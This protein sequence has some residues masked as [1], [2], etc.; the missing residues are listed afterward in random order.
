MHEIKNKI[1]C[2]EKKI[3]VA[4]RTIS[5]VRKVYWPELLPHTPE[6]SHSTHWLIRAFVM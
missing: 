6:E 2:P 5:G 4:P 1:S 3:I